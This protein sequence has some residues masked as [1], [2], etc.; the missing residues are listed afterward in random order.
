MEGAGGELL[1]NGASEQ[2]RQPVAEL[3]GGLVR[4]CQHADAAR[5]DA[6]SAHEVGDAVH[7]DSSLAAARPRDDEQRALY[8][9]HGLLL[10]LVEALEEV[11]G[12]HT[13]SV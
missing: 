6:H 10:R 8:V 1:G 5:P 12:R 11:V 2:P 7:D 4:E 13:E 9:L 3:A